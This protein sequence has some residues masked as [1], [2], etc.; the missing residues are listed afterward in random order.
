MAATESTKMRMAFGR[1]DAESAAV[2]QAIGYPAKLDK[3]DEAESVNAAVCK[4]I[5][6]MAVRENKMDAAAVVDNKQGSLF[7]VREAMWHYV[8]DWTEEGKAERTVIFKPILDLLQE[9]DAPGVRGD[10][11][12]LVPGSG[13]GRMAW[14]ISELG[15]FDIAH[16]LVRIR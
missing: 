16:T 11:T 5:G 4:A 9:L 3:M 12:V 1:L 8:R 7:R 6:D 15:T 14:E 10:K 13:L 2:G